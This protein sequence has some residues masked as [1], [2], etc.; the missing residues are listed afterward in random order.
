M[1]EI[2]ILSRKGSI[3]RKMKR[4]WEG[5]NIKRENLVVYSQMRL[6]KLKGLDKRV[7]NHLKIIL[8]NIR[9]NRSRVNIR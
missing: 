9:N 8:N 7:I 1:K 6:I 4:S 2:I 3:G 5:G